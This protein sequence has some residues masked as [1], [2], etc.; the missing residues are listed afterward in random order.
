[1]ALLDLSGAYLRVRVIR[2]TEARFTVRLATLEGETSTPVDIQGWTFQVFV[3]DEDGEDIEGTA[4]VVISDED[5]PRK[6]VLIVLPATMTDM[7]PGSYGMRIMAS[8]VGVEPVIVHGVLDVRL[9]NGRVC[10]G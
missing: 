7:E 8:V 9:D 4:T 1:M 3:K 6:Y 10:S 5:E 2:G